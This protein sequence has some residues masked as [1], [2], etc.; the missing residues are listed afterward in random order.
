MVSV[1]ILV[2]EIGRI[3]PK[4]NPSDE[5]GWGDRMIL[6]KEMQSLTKSSPTLMFE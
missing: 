6:I 3:G 2:E 4:K 5:D 1:G